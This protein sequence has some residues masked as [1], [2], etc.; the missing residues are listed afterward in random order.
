MKT[1]LLSLLFLSL[2]LTIIPSAS[3][4]SDAHSLPSDVF[5]DPTTPG[6]KDLFL[7]CSDL[8]DLK[9]SDQLQVSITVNKGDH[10]MICA[11]P[12]KDFSVIPFPRSEENKE[13]DCFTSIS[14]YPLIHNDYFS[15]RPKRVVVFEYEATDVGQ[16][17]ISYNMYH[18][19]NNDQYDIKTVSSLYILVKVQEAP[20]APTAPEDTK[21]DSTATTTPSEDVA[22]SGQ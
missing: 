19:D 10:I 12:L 9:P 11:D 18:N 14:N 7:Y 22:P 20:T 6:A 21:S 8:A 15:R 16:G 1:K 3:A 2:S 5:P 17:W 13:K 4:V